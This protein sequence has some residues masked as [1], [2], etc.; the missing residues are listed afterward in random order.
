MIDNFALLLTHGLMALA[1]WRLL[2]RSDLDRDPPAV[3][4]SAACAPAEKQRV[5]DRI[6]A[7]R[8]RPRA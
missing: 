8:Q 2:M 5:A 7:R 3:E 6:R 4:Q 1:A